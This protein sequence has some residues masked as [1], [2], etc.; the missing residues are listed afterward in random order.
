MHSSKTSSSSLPLF[1]PPWSATSFPFHSS[2]WFRERKKLVFFLF[3]S[4]D[5]EMRTLLPMENRIF[6]FSMYLYLLF[7]FTPPSS[8]FILLISNRYYR[9]WFLLS[10]APWGENE[11]NIKIKNLDAVRRERMLLHDE[12]KEG[13]PFYVSVLF[14]LLCRVLVSAWC[15]QRR[16]KRV[17]LSS[18]P[19]MIVVRDI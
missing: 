6:C 19:C 11:Q 14:G 18:V 17:R 1:G 16:T 8:L 12:Y 5:R 4:I 9:L 10:F 2:V 13:R 3:S 7:M 15:A